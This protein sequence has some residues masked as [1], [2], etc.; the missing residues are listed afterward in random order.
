MTKKMISIAAMSVLGL[1]ILILIF[2]FFIVVEP[3]E[4]VII[5]N[6]ATGVLRV[7]KSEGMKFLVPFLERAYVYEI[8]A[9]TFTMSESPLEGEKKGDDSLQALTADGQ[10]VF[11]DLS[12]RFHPDPEKLDQLHRRLGPDYMT[13]L[14]RPQV[15]SSV[16]T[17]IADYPVQDV[18]STKRKT[19]QATIFTDLKP[20]FE[21]N[22]II[23]DE[24]L[25][26]NVQFTPEYQKAIENK[27][28]A[29]QEAQ[30]MTYI[31]EQ[32]ELEKKRKIIE[33]EGDAESIRLRGKALQENPS[34]IQY[35]YVKLLA[36]NIQ[37]IV[38]D[39]NSILNFSDFLKQQKK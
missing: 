35:E 20:V 31:L 8:R 16:R 14:I 2:R 1:M 30:R 22:N 13:R 4:R 18:Y 29:Q 28:I 6:N 25:V 9:R 23:L 21:K 32:Q 10:N 11:L 36:P 33:A 38:T 7:V 37:A 27:Q 26:R 15:R 39:Q 17:I 24:I 5:F 19:I 12:I 3:G 34:L